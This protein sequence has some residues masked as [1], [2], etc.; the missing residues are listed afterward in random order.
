MPAPSSE[1]PWGGPSAAADKAVNSATQQQAA[2]SRRRLM[3][4]SSS[5]GLPE[6]RSPSEERSR[7]LRDSFARTR[8]MDLPHHGA[9]IVGARWRARRA[10]NA[11]GSEA[12]RRET[13][14]TS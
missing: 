14:R 3:A 11:S 9:R 5:L 10:T 8:S 12:P 2:I 13:P 6:L 1:T 4:S 7:D